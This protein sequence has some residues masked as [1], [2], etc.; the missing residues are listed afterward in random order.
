MYKCLP[1]LFCLF[2]LYPAFSQ[3]HSMVA[4]QVFGTDCFIPQTMQQGFNGEKKQTTTYALWH[5]QQSILLNQQKV[6]IGL[7][8]ELA[9]RRE[10]QWIDLQWHNTRQTAT[11]IAS[12]PTAH[13][14][15]VG[16]GTDTIRGFRSLRYPGIYPGIDLVYVPDRRGGFEYRFILKPGA[17]LKQIQFSYTSAT[18]LQ[19]QATENQLMVKNTQGKQLLHESGLH[20]Y[21]NDGTPVG[22]RYT[23][24]ADQR[25]SFA[26]DKPHDRS[27]TL[28]IDPWVVPV[29]TLTGSTA[30]ISQMGFD[31]DYDANGNLLVLGGGGGVNSTSQAPKIAKYDL[32]GNLLWTFLGNLAAPVWNASPQLNAASSG[33]TVGNF[34]VDK[35]SGKVYVGQGYSSSGS[36]VIRLTQAGLYDGFISVPNNQV[37][38][39]WEMKFNCSNGRVIAMG[40]SPNSNLNFGIVDTS[41][42]VVST[43]CVT[44]AIGYQQDIVCSTLD[45]NGDVFL[46]FASSGTPS[47]DNKIYKLTSNFASVLWNTPSGYSTFAQ[48]DNKIYTGLGSFSAGFNCLAVNASY[49]FYYDGLHLKA[50]DKSNGNAVGSPVVVPGHLE[51]LQGG[52]FANSCNE[53]FIGGNNGNVLRYGFNGSSFNI[54][55]TLYFSGQTGKAVYDI[56]NNPVN[57]L[58]YVSGNG[59]VST[60]DQQST[61]PLSP[62]GNI[63]LSASISCP[64][65]AYVTI[66]NADPN[67]SYTFFWV[68]STTNTPVQ[69]NI[70]TP[71]NPTVGIANLMTGHTYKVTVLKPSPCQIVSN[72]ILFN[73][74]CGVIQVNRCPGQ[75]YTLSNNTVLS[76][77]GLYTDT[78][79]NVLGQDSIIYVQFSNYPVYSDSVTASICDS[80]AYV[81][82]GGQSVNTAGIYISNLQT[83]HGC[84]SII[85]TFLNQYNSTSFAQTV[86]ICSDQSFILPNNTTVTTAG[87]YVTTIP[88]KAGCDSVVTTNLSVTQKPANFLG[89]DTMLCNQGQFDVDITTAGAVAY[90]WNDGWL[91]PLR[92]IDSKGTYIAGITVPP[93]PLA[94]DTLNVTACACRVFIP[95]AFTPNG[96]GQNDLFRAVFTCVT[97]PENFTLH[98][99]NRWGNLVFFTR[100][101]DDGWDGTYLGSREDGGVYFY[102]LKY[103]DPENGTETQYK[104]D[105]TLIR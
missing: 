32:N 29:T 104:G 86:S 27:K 63:Q 66:T 3:F 36:K 77:P 22:I 34:V 46:I 90:Q 102:Y 93:C 54:Q 4:D 12:Q 72:T 69:T 8:D 17:D 26:L 60:T 55:D 11:A 52:I 19:V 78:L 64:D 18:A 6:R 79:L 23:V 50:F 48:G 81:L 74:S 43:A 31:V 21:Y 40:G 56:S 73:F 1:F 20:A 68:D 82:P 5:K 101:Q 76:T 96:D 105:L 44:G 94:S 25:I 95:S 103:I 61:C 28:I 87:T 59:F 24:G 9:G 2:S 39:I 15:I 10:P 30:T 100:L 38:Q 37:Q 92:T 45:D 97:P 16:N 51:R 49:V 41:S 33:G 42:G 99:V 65:S 88:N 14:F 85:T 62:S 53:V 58:L 57:N 75:T 98:I 35:I 89:N 13:Y 80:N 70:S 67:V 84:D 47:I 83:I 91:Q 7:E 71:G